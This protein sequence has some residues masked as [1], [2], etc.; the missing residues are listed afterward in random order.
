MVQYVQNRYAPA[1]KLSHA[2][3]Q[4]SNMCDDEDIHREEFYNWVYINMFIYTML[5]FITKS[6]FHIYV[7]TKAWCKVSKD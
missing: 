7:V 5:Y 1:V 6:L 3:N 4:I 2:T